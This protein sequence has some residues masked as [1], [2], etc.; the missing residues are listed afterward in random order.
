MCSGGGKA[1]AQ[2]A[3]RARK[4]EEERQRKIDSGMQ[5][6][7]DAFGTKKGFT[8]E[9]YAQKEK[10]YSAYYKPQ[11]NQQYGDA[12]E[13]LLYGL[14]RN[15]LVRSS[16]GAKSFGTLDRDRG[17]RLNEVASNATDYANQT[18]K[19]VEA[20]KQNVIQQL[21][22]TTNPQAAAAAATNAANLVATGGNKFSPI[23]DLFSGVAGLAATSNQ[24]QAY[25]GPGLAGF[26]SV[27]NIF[28]KGYSGTPV[29][30]SGSSKVIG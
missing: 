3:G 8:P 25:G 14:A 17:L 21:Y 13:Q 29:S 12:R 28:N 19:Q 23:G 16:A 4:D 1:S 22:A 20:A 5:S 18:R 24:A 11:V 15:G 9:F 7:N 27:G 26:N 2:A 30:G 10:D 6:I